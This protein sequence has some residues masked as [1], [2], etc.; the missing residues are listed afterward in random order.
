MPDADV[1]GVPS[2]G[3]TANAAAV[4]SAITQKVRSHFIVLMARLLLTVF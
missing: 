4:A 1:T 2:N 3:N